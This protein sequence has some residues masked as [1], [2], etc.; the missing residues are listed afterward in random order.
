[1]HVPVYITVTVWRVLIRFV[2]SLRA[3]PTLNQVSRKYRHSILSKTSKTQSILVSTKP[4]IEFFDNI[5]YRTSSTIIPVV[6]NGKPRV[7]FIFIRFAFFFQTLVKRH[8]EF[9]LIYNSE[10]SKA[11]PKS[12]LVF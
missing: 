3:K 2:S 4:S 11:R 7:V 9:T 6:V 10:C 12:G 8:Q 5:E 1:M